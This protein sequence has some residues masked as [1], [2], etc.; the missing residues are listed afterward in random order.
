[1]R[2]PRAVPRPIESVVFAG[3]RGRSRKRRGSF[4]VSF[5]ELT[6]QTVRELDLGIAGKPGCRFEAG[7]AVG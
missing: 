6:T 3:S 4:E 7:I 5:L 1:M 2:A